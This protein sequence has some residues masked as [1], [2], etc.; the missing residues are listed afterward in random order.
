M[1]NEFPFEKTVNVLPHGNVYTIS[2]QSQPQV[3]ELYDYFYKDSTIYLDRKYKKW[4]KF[5]KI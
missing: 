3:K 4:S 2:I 5:R 1:L